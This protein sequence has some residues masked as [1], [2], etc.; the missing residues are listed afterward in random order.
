MVVVLAESSSDITNG[1]SSVRITFK[2]V[3][4]AI[5]CSD[6]T[7]VC[8]SIGKRMSLMATV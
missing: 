2:N 7:R 1:Q 5:N 8:Y 3:V 4:L 6:I